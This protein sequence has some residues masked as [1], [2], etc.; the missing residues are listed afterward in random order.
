MAALRQADQLHKHI[1]SSS[2]QQQNHTEVQN[3]GKRSR[4]AKVARAKHSESP[5]I[6]GP[7]SRGEQ[8]CAGNVAELSTEI[9]GMRG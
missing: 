4:I 9:H 6:K 1:H 8:R 7:T 2:G 5:R 3:L